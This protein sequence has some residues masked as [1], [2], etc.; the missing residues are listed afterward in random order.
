MLMIVVR[1][2][3]ESISVKISKIRGRHTLMR[4]Q[5]IWFKWFSW[6][7]DSDTT[8]YHRFIK[9]SDRDRRV[10]FRENKDRTHKSNIKAISGLY[11]LLSLAY[12]WTTSSTRKIKESCNKRTYEWYGWVCKK[13]TIIW[14]IWIRPILISNQKLIEWI[15]NLRNICLNILAINS[16]YCII[17]GIFYIIHWKL[18]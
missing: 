12:D 9:V 13:P 2:F 17:L 11:K 16:T 4:N 7:I 1:V 10:D 15:N 3:S 14:E 8:W 6:L 5:M 18:K